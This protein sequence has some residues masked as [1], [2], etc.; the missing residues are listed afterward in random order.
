M[1]HQVR[2]GGSKAS[3]NEGKLR[4]RTSCFC[5]TSICSRLRLQ[6]GDFPIGKRVEKQKD[7]PASAFATSR[8]CDVR[9]TVWR[10]DGAQMGTVCANRTHN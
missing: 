5:L 9:V 2:A 4:E 10:G 8:R 1:P 3:I 6:Q 7:P